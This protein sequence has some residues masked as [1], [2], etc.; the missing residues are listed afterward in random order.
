ME[1]LRDYIRAYNMTL[2]AGIVRGYGGSIVRKWA[3]GCG[4]FFQRFLWA[5]K[6]NICVRQTEQAERY[7]CVEATVP[8]AV[9][10][11]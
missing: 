1:D 5:V 3:E 8:Q 7:S 10:E 9:N 11:L 4:V 2:F 6:E